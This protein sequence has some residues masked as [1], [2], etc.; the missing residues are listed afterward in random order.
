MSDERRPD[1]DPLGLALGRLP[2]GLHVL[3]V[4]VDGQTT[5]MLA[6]WVQ[7]AGFKPPMLT[8]ALRKDGHVR[9]WVERAGGFTLNQIAAGQK[10][11][12]RHFARGFAPGAAAFEGISLRA[13]LHANGPVL[14]D[15]FAYLDARIRSAI[16]A[17]DHRVFLAEVVAGSLLMT[18]G[19]PM[20]HVRHNG[21][22]Y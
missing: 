15:A 21:F 6:S 12:V 11:L 9:E 8:M 4:R 5:G 22:H 16:D 19:E 13:D 7:Q 20:I 17:A 18:D 14:A 10:T 3:T 1:P 2:S